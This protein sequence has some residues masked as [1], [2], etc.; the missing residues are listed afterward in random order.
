MKYALLIHHD[1]ANWGDI[2]DEE[3]QAI[4]AEYMEI[5]ND[6]RVFGGAELQSKDTATTVT[7]NGGGDA[8]LTDGPF[9]SA[10]EYL[11]GFFLVEADNL[12]EATAL[13]AKIPALRSGGAVEVRAI[14]ER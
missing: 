13:A 5:R 9:I 8:L 4:T 10:K 14:V 1:N 2:S 7:R 3:R 11:G 12:D 6:P